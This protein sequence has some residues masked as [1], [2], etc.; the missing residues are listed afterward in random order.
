M[1]NNKKYSNK[2]LLVSQLGSMLPYHTKVDYRGSIVDL[3]EQC[4]SVS[5]ELCRPYLRPMSSMTRDES[6]EL[7]LYVFSYD[8]TEYLGDGKWC[9]EDYIYVGD[10]IYRLNYNEV[11]RAIE[12]L[13]EHHFD[14]RGLIEMGLAVEAPEDMYR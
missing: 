4:R 10:G 8:D 13:N 6:K 9:Y 3:T 11:S 14:H 1:K 7:T 12:W 5:L 2:Q